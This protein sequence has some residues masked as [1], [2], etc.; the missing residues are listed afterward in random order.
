MHNIGFF[1]LNVV[2]SKFYEVIINDRLNGGH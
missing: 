1:F 2:P